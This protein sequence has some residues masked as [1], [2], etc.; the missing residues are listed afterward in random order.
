VCTI[1]GGL[2]GAISL[3][4]PDILDW[5]LKTNDLIDLLLLPFLGLSVLGFLGFGIVMALPI[6]IPAG[7][8]AAGLLWWFRSRWTF[9]SQAAW[10]LL[11]ALFGLLLASCLTVPWSALVFKKVFF[12]LWLEKPLSLLLPS[13]VAGATCGATLAWLEPPHKPIGTA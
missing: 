10:I 9:E 8:L 4:T 7:A 1:G 6:G 12:A 5:V 13:A 2:T 11:G 3:L